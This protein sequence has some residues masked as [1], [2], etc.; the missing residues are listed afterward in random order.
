MNKKRWIIGGHIIHNVKDILYIRF[1]TDYITITFI[2]GNT[3]KIDLSTEEISNVKLNYQ[4]QFTP[5]FL[6]KE[7]MHYEHNNVSQS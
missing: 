2:Y 5:D 6:D 3:M 1:Y 4:K 7:S